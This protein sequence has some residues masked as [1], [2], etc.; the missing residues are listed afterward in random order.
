MESRLLGINLLGD[1]VRLQQIARQP[2]TPLSMDAPER[3]AASINSLL[4][5][6]FD[7][8]LWI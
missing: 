8:M 7:D 6:T 4:I 3:R 2:V 1:N 5:Q